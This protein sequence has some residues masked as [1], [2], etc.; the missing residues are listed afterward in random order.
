MA[1]INE[2]QLQQL[3]NNYKLTPATLMTKLDPSWI[4]APWLQY[5]SYRLAQVV[6]R[7]NCGLCISAPPRHGKSTLVT[8]ALP[9]WVM[10]NF[11]TKNVVI[12]TYGEELS[13]DFSRD[14]RDF[15]E[16]SQ[17]KLS[18]RLRPDVKRVA[19]FQ[20]VHGGAIKAVG[21][22]GTITGRGADVLIIDDYIKEPTEA[23]SPTYLE[24]LWNW[25]TTVARTRLEPGAVVIIVATRWVP[26][27]LHGRIEKRQAQTGSKF[28]D[29]IKIPAIAVEVPEDRFGRKPGEALF[30]E[31]YNIDALQ[32]IKAELTARW[33]NAMFQQD[34]Q[35]DEASVANPDWLQ[36]I[37]WDHFTKMFNESSPRV[38]KAARGW[39]FAS[40]NKGGD[41]TAGP[42][43]YHNMETDQTVIVD[44]VHGQ[45]GPDRVEREFK[46]ANEKD[47]AFIEYALER[48]PG[49]S[50]VF[51]TKHFT[52]LLPLP[53]RHIKDYPS[54]TK[55]FLK[56]QP[57]LAHC[58]NLGGPRK[59][60]YIKAPWNQKFLDEFGSFPEGDHDDIMD[61]L[62]TAYNHITGKKPLAGTWGRGAGDRTLIRNASIAL[63]T[64]ADVH[65]FGQSLPNTPVNE[66][67]ARKSLS[68]VWGR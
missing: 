68:V 46:G 40:I 63:P 45:F 10:E 48:E 6:A 52:E 42:L 67:Q 36:Q 2:A 64:V 30:P 33:F 27:D 39:D 5:L 13:T 7:G 14:I 1:S 24:G 26:G 56:A 59:V 8:K 62:S 23:M 44:L 18:I 21:L 17:D 61:G 35:S 9:L 54:S 55:K 12:A 58:E 25:F 31:R 28:Y 16:G 32:E 66:P 38:W 34:P 11:P 65:A 19:H 37:E 4:A 50:G 60:F 15:I 53:R 41:W 47:P 20:N 51:A 49:S 43:L 22:K 3:I 29:H 57:F